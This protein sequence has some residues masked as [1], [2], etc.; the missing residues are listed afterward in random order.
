[1]GDIALSDEERDSLLLRSYD[2]VENPVQDWEEQVD[3]IEGEGSGQKEP[4][5]SNREKSAI[6]ERDSINSI[7]RRPKNGSFT[8]SLK[9]CLRP[10][11]YAGRNGN[12]QKSLFF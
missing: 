8:T 1:M 10:V 12:Q 11:N 7:G 2:L 4:K 6:G 5:L 9:L 3:G